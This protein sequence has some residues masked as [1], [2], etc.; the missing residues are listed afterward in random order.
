MVAHE[1]MTLSNSLPSRRWSRAV[2]ITLSDTNS[3][4][5]CQVGASR[6]FRY[7]ANTSAT[8]GVVAFTW[9]TDNSVAVAVPI[10]AYGYLEGGYWVNARVT[11]TTVGITLVGLIG[12]EG[13][14]A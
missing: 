14:D 8:S 12:I 11:G 10:A 2:A 5:N 13:V 4:K 1:S 6:P 9:E 7:I 3:D